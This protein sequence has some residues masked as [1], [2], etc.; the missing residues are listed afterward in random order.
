[1]VA[2]SLSMQA[3]KRKSDNYLAMIRVKNYIKWD[4]R[5]LPIRIYERISKGFVRRHFGQLNFKR[6]SQNQ[7]VYRFKN[8]RV[9]P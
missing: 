9:H 2:I 5:A 3:F 7:H 6:S 1:M 8:I 4:L